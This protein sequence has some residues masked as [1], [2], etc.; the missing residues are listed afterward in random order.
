MAESKKVEEKWCHLNGGHGP[1]GWNG[2]RYFCSGHAAPEDEE[3]ATLG[4]LLS[5]ALGVVQSGEK[6][7]TA[8]W[9][10][11][12]AIAMVVRLEGQRD[13]LREAADELL[14]VADLRGDTNL[15]LPEDDEKLWTARM[16]TAWEELRAA[17]ERGQGE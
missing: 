14:E 10:L 5:E 13:A 9:K 1:H 4:E 7:L 12:Q 11:T 2:K 3:P 8:E 15:P 17:L 6:L 16:Q